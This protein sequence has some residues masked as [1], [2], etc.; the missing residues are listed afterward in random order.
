M[1]GFR[2]SVRSCAYEKYSQFSGRTGRAEFWWF[3]LAL[4]LINCTLIVIGIILPFIQTSILGGFT[5]VILSPFAAALTR[6][7]MGSRG[8]HYRGY[9][10]NRGNLLHALLGEV[11]YAGCLWPSLSDIPFPG[12]KG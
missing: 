4:F 3:I 10:R 1:P 11:C 6:R 9:R 7:Q 5:L 8:F 2:E 12:F